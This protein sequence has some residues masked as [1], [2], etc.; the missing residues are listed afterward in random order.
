LPRWLLYVLVW[1]PA[2]VRT[3]WELR[4]GGG[5]VA[6]KMPQSRW[7]RAARYRRMWASR[8]PLNAVKLLLLWP[9]RLRL[10]RWRSCLATTGIERFEQV[11][12]TGRP[13]IL[14][15]LH[16]GPTTAALPLLRRDGL[17]AAALVIRDPAE[18][19]RFRTALQQVADGVNGLD[20]VPALISV[21]DLE[22]AVGFLNPGHV[23]VLSV[24]GPRGRHLW[25]TIDDHALCLSTAVCQMAA[26]RQAVIVP[27]L[28]T[29]GPLFRVTMHFGEPVPDALV[30]DYRRHQAACDHLHR[31][32][33]PVV[34]AFPEQCYPVLTAARRSPADL[35]VTARLDA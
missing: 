17:P 5:R 2:A 31:E 14:A 22:R 1:P 21:A 11:R 9:D 6:V 10:P 27:C 35:G 29:A 20:G 12:A 32:F 15:T 3:A 19:A 28:L 23:L 7:T 33:L 4:F 13:V 18:R 26:M 30:V 34:K 16:F 8:V 25:S 24:D